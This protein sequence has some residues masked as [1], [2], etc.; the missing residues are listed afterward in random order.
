MKPTQ[1]RPEPVIPWEMETPSK[2]LF[3]TD[4]NNQFLSDCS[5]VH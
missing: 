5:F 4:I 2:F 3:P 1:E